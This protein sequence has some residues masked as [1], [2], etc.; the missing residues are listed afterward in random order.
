MMRNGDE[1]SLL[2]FGVDGIV[3][4]SAGH[5]PGSVSVELASHEALV[6]DLIASGILIGGIAFTGRAIRP[7]FEDNAERVSRE[8]EG[9]VHRGAT[10]FYMGHGGPLG[11]AEV[12][13]HA[14]SLPKTLRHRCAAGK[15]GHA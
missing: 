14:R 9:L 2:E 11:I 6:G 12:V 5:T 1:I 3:R 7:P 15:C 4:H 8:L 10:R 13:R